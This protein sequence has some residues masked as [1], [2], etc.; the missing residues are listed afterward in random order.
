MLHLYP[1]LL[2]H[3]RFT[4]MLWAVFHLAEELTF[5]ADRIGRLPKPDY[6]HLGHDLKRAYSQ[7]GGEWIAYTEHL[8]ESYPFLFSLASRI[9]PFSSNPTAIISDGNQA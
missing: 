2:E 5:R 3:E 6:E 7:I 1:S 8:K 9:N 4:N